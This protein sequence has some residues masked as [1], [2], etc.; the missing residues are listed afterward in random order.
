MYLLINIKN[1]QNRRNKKYI[2]KAAI[3]GRYINVLMTDESLACALLE[4][5]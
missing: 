1:A 3:K 4:E 2:A 5:D